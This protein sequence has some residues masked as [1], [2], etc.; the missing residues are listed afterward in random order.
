MKIAL[1]IYPIRSYVRSA[2]NK[3]ESICRY[4]RSPSGI[5]GRTKTDS[6]EA[7]TASSRRMTNLNQVKY[8]HLLVV[9]EHAALRMDTLGRTVSL[10]RTNEGL[11]SFAIGL[12]PAA[13]NSWCTHS[14]EK[15]VWLI[16]LYLVLLLLFPSFTTLVTG[17]M[18]LALVGI[19]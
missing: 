4:Q 15:L 3:G 7:K 5:T 18:I 12:A 13:G 9:P 19:I 1:D 11:V 6:W 14:Q 2:T 17:A 8:T 16:S 10:G